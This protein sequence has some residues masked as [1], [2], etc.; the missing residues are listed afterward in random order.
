MSFCQKYNCMKEERNGNS[1]MN[2]EM[3]SQI[4]FNV[5]F[6]KPSM[7]ERCAVGWGNFVYIVACVGAKYVFR[8]SGQCNAYDNSIFWLEK[9]SSIEIPVPKVIAK[10]KFEEYEYLILEY[11]EGRDL[12]VVYSQLEDEDKKAI[13]KDIVHIQQ[14]VSALKLENVEKNWSWS[15][16]VNEMLERARGRIAENGYFEIEKVE[17]LKGQMGQMEDYF[18]SVKPIAYLDDISSK[19][20]LIY[21][22]RIS[23][24][25][26][27][28]WI[29]TG[30][31]L[32]FA[33]LTNMALRDLGYDTDYVTY[34]LEEMQVN[35]VQKRAF[36]FYTLMYC[37]DFMGERGMRFGDKTVEVNEQII[38][39]LNAIYDSLWAEWRYSK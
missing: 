6:Q 17:R 27:I 39:R 12:G 5:F 19:N 1:S 3:I 31:M 16:F 22:G 10:G 4:C 34:I 37:V 25:I 2:E 29:G 26:D 33:A 38:D 15:V 11:M 14:L 9:L 35:D 18:S 24:I 8:C 30:D 23:G 32:T 7:V 36:L 20:L 13:A 21:N 28:D